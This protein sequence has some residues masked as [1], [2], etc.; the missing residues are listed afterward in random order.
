MRDRTALAV[1]HGV[2]GVCPGVGVI[3]PK[4]CS[5]QIP[6]TYQHLKNILVDVLRSAE[7][8]LYIIVT[9]FGFLLLSFA[10][11]EQNGWQG[12]IRAG[13]VSGLAISCQSTEAGGERISRA[14]TALPF[15]WDYVTLDVEDRHSE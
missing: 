2:C 7:V 4:Q 12:D 3:S 6:L 8:M 5:D 1:P 10:H 9:I 11:L 14:H 15:T 13:V